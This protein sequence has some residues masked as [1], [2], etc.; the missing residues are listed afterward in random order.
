MTNFV[1]KMMISAF[2]MMTFA[3]KVIISQCPD[4]TGKGRIDCTNI[5]QGPV[6]S[7]RNVGP[8]FEKE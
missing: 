7:L 1:F 4:P 2:I 3:L 8:M 6:S 5:T